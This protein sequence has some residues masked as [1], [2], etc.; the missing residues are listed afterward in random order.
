MLKKLFRRDG[1]VFDRCNFRR[2]F[3][4]ACVAIGLGRKLAIEVVTASAFG[5]HRVTHHASGVK[6]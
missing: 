5:F 1:P 4:G 2:A 6:N 3:I